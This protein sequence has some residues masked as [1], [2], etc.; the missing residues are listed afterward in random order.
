[1]SS[2]R[3]ATSANHHRP[4]LKLASCSATAPANANPVFARFSLRNQTP[5]AGRAPP[6]SAGMLLVNLESGDAALMS[7]AAQPELGAICTTPPP[8][9]AAVELAGVLLVDLMLGDRSAD[10]ARGPSSARTSNY[11]YT[12]TVSRLLQPACFGLE[13]C[14][15]LCR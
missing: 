1:L 2:P 9:A 8:I 5:R 15:A 6:P 11:S 13:R 14:S 7:A 10:V 4:A 12:S 3:S